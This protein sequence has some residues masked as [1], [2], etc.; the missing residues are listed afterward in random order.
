MS[1]W[2]RHGNNIAGLIALLIMLLL[3]G[4]YVAAMWFDGV[5]VECEDSMGHQN[6]RCP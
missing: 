2:D 5:V 1:L 6:P 3:V 4:G